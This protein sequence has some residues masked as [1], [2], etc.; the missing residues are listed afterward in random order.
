[1]F[2]LEFIDSIHENDGNRIQRCWKYEMVLFRAT[3]HKNYAIEAFT[4]L[5][6]EKYLLSPRL[7]LQLKG[8]EQS[9]HMGK[10]VKIFHV[11]CIWSF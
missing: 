4:L 9:T 5:A 8:E 3:R 2:F 11:I 6:Q 10:Q 1:M 7:S